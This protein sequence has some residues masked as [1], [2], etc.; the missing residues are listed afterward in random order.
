MQRISR[1]LVSGTVCVLVILLCALG[2]LMES[3][4]TS[5]AASS[6]LKVQYMPDNTSTPTN[7][8]QPA[9][10]VVNS[11][12]GSVDLS[13]LTMRYWFT[14]DTAQPVSV[15]CDYAALGCGAIAE[16]AA[17]LSQSV[18]TADYYLQIGFTSGSLAGN[19]NTGKIKLR[20]YKSDYSNFTQTNDYS[21]NASFSSP[22]DWPNVTLYQNGILIWGTEPGGVSAT[23]T[24]T[25]TQGST[26]TPTA[27]PTNTPTPTP[28][29]TPLP[30]NFSQAQIDAA[31]ASPLLA[32]PAPTIG[33]SGRPGDSPSAVYH[34]K[35]FYF[36]ALV[37]WYNPNA[38]TSSGASVAS[39]FVASIGNVIAGGNEPDANG[40]LEGWG[41]NDVAQGLLLARNEP[42]AW[43]QLNASQQGKVN[44]LM[45]AL[46]VTGNF[47][48]ND[49]NNFNQD[50][51]YALEGSQCKFNKSYNPNYRE[52]Y[53][54]IEI[55]A[56]LYFGP[57]ALN[58][59]F[60][61]FDYTSFTQQLQSA[62]FTNILAAWAGD[63]ALLMSGGSDSC[64][65]SGKG[66]REAFTYNSIPLSNPAG[67]FDQLATFTYQD[68]VTSTNCSGNAHIDDGTSSPF[69]GQ[70]GMEHEVNTTDSSGCRSDALYVYEGWMNSISSRTT[71]T[72]LGAWGCG[73]TQTND[74]H[75]EAIGSGDLLYKLQHGYDGYYLGTTRLVTE[76]LPSSDGPS[77]KGFFFDQQ[78]WN[79]VLSQVKPC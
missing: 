66:V 75:L 2:V 68:S 71:I 1:Y 51:D 69:Q 47:N 54:N 7:K 34:A 40:G 64:G 25:P 14:R 5:H 31:V 32:F 46:A 24:S 60:T 77:T 63:Q 21:F 26:A 73:T 57:S 61:S 74:I 8:I 38:T 20:A 19:A 48:F 53:L 11:G 12:S 35:A 56:S 67:I 55:A 70:Q 44:L 65:G 30:A 42:A 9:L 50:M 39:R 29:G 13:Q 52:G 58:N 43:N 10:Q 37:L 33:N 22:T 28:T 16:T 76:T 49:A 18:T 6:T 79:V 23:P 4:G 59:F 45:Q 36:M 15:T 27:T 3:P 62:G 78:I 41:H 72:L 17:A